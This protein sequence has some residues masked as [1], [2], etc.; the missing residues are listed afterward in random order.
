M[1]EEALLLKNV[2]A[3]VRWVG[4][5]LLRCEV[6]GSVVTVL[7]AAAAGVGLA[8]GGAS[9]VAALILPF[10]NPLPVLASSGMVIVGGGVFGWLALSRK[11]KSGIYLLDR[12]KREIVRLVRESPK[13]RWGFEE[14]RRVETAIDLTDG[15][16][17]D[18][19]PAL[20]AW[21]VLVTAGGRRLRIAKGG[22]AELERVEAALGEV[23]L[24]RTGEAG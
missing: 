5:G 4:P 24:R 22:K 18:L 15:T 16:R 3:Q 12:N 23:G 13:E 1:A 9:G 11:R 8:I 14:I 19:L 17:M 10:P 7:L 21:L 20:P 2:S 6:P